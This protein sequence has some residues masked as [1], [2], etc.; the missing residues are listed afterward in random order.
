MPSWRPD[1]RVAGR[2]CLSFCRRDRAQGF[3]QAVVVELG[4]PFQSGQLDGFLGLPR[5]AAMDQLRLVQAVD[6]LDQ[7]VVVAV[8]LAAH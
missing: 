1:W 7:G 3:H 2:S 5:R 6:R 8:A 4:D